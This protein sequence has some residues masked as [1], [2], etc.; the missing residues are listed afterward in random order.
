MDSLHIWTRFASSQKSN[1]FLLLR[2]WPCL[3]RRMRG[4]CLPIAGEGWAAYGL[5]TPFAY[6]PPKM[7]VCTLFAYRLA[8]PR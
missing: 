4:L 1:G 2:R 5:W 3:R 7:Y 8:L 6:V